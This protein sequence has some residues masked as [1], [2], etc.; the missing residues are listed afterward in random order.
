[1]ANETGS[2]NRKSGRGNQPGMKAGYGRESVGRPD[3]TGIR[4]GESGEVIRQPDADAGQGTPS[5]QT[6]T[7]EDMSGQM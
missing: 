2:V 4:K 3:E 5:R 6:S 7:A 1:M